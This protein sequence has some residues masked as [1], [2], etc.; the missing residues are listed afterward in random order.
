MDVQH[1]DGMPEDQQVAAVIALA[2][3]SYFASSTREHSQSMLSSGRWTM[4]GRLEAHG[5]HQ[6]SGRMKRLWG[7]NVS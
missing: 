2:I 5:V 4:A 6:S 7:R 1:I 3:E